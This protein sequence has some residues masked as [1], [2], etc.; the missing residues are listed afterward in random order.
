MNDEGGIYKSAVQWA[1]G[2]YELKLEKKTR[3]DGLAI[4]RGRENEGGVAMGLAGENEK[5]QG[6]GK[7]KDGQKKE[8]TL[9]DIL[10]YRIRGLEHQTA[11]R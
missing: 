10:L 7:G 3:K 4:N 9:G 6:R 8:S 5:K 2:R 1:R 11:Q